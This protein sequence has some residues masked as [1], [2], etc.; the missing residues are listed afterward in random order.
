MRR[1]V[2]QFWS[3]F[4]QQQVIHSGRRA[5]LIRVSRDE[6]IIRYWGESRATAVPLALLSAPPKRRLRPSV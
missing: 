4:E 3:G 2:A 5:T 1:S 6:A